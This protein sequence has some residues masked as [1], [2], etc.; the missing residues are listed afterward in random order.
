MDDVDLAVKAAKKAFARDS[1]WRTMDASGRGRLLYQLADAIAQN[2]E[3]LTALEAMDAGKPLDS[4]KG[5][6][7]FAINT[8]RYHAGYADKIHGKVSYSLSNYIFYSPY[9]CCV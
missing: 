1:P 3:Y 6:I 9:L 2:M 8:F 7:E 4:A 5:D